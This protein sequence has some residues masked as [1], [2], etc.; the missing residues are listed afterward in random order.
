MI[1]SGASPQQNRSRGAA[2]LGFLPAWFD[3]LSPNARGITLVTIGSLMLVIMAVVAKFLGGRLPAFELLAFRSGVGFLFLLPLFWRDPLEPFRTKRP[4]MHL[5]RGIFGSIGNFAFFWTITHMLLADSTALQFSRPLWTIPLAIL[6][7]KEKVGLSRIMISLV[8]FAGVL[9]YA[10]PFT[11]GFDPNAMI[12]A[13]GGLAAALVIISIKRLSTSE[14]TRVIMFYYAF[15]NFVFVLGP[16]WWVWV[17]PNAHEWPLLILIGF[18]GIAGQGMI[19]RGVQY[20]DATALAPLDYSRILYAALLG[21]L[22]FGE[23]PGLWSWLGMALIVASSIY[24]VVSEKRR[25]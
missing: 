22:V 23:V 4:G 20:G 5:M 3:R 14:P 25:K 10:R 24:L 11:G 8:G 12:G 17:T 18:L 16:A 19:T 21:Y 2:A 13:I 7:L 15:W 1:E 6:I 9:M